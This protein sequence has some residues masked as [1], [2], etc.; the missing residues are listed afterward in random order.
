[1]TG[2][3][4]FQKIS[5]L[6]Y[7]VISVATKMHVPFRGNTTEILKNMSKLSTKVIF[8]FFCFAV[9]K[10]LSA[11]GDWLGFVGI[12]LPTRRRVKVS[13]FYFGQY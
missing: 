12:V 3:E 1:M 10:S 8:Y 11:V 6:K 13:F 9:H 5:F 4:G 7:F 2:K